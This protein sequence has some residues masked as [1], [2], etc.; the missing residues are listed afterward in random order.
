MTY[1][2]IGDGEGS[3]NDS[4]DW[5]SIAGKEGRKP[6]NITVPEKNVGIGGSGGIVGIV[7]ISGREAVAVLPVER[8]EMVISVFPVVLIALVV[9]I[10]G[11]GA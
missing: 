10:V 4:D 11:N 9:L 2:G 6:T 3:G 5:N 8:G 1:L 7:V